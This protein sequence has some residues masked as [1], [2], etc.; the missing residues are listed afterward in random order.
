[1]HGAY[2]FVEAFEK[3]IMTLSATSYIATLGQFRSQAVSSLIGTEEDGSSLFMAAITGQWP[4]QGASGDLW[5]ALAP[6]SSSTGLSANGRNTALFDPESAYRMMTVINNKDVLYKAQYFE[7]NSMKDGLAS[8]Q[9]AAQSLDITATTDNDSIRSQLQGFVD[10]YNGWIKQ[11]GEDMQQGGLLADTQAAQV[12]RHELDQSIKNMFFGVQ[13][14]V[15]GLADLGISIDAKTGN[16]VLDTAKLDGM[17]ASN[18]HGVADTV[19]AFAANF[20]EAAKLLNSDGNF[21]PRQLD[22][23]NRAI[24]YI[25]DHSSALQAEFGTGDVAHPTGAVAQALDAYNRVFGS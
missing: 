24:H 8:M 6:A 2:V 7:L 1:V 10:R 23:L 19:Q 17:L 16:A 18:K 3:S 12:A 9:Q 21:M 22:N 13:D 11:F 15:H 25:D 5:S 20:A 4:S 14:G